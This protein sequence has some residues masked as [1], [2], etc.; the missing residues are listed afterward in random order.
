MYI[1][2]QKDKLIIS[3]LGILVMMTLSIIANNLFVEYSIVEMITW[4]REISVFLVIL[5]IAQLAIL[6]GMRPKG[7]YI[8]IVNLVLYYSF[9]FSHVFLNALE[10]DFGTN[11]RNSVFFRFDFMIV[12]K[13]TIL[14]I[15]A[16]IGLFL[17]YIFMYLFGNFEQ[18]DRNI[19]Y[20]GSCNKENNLLLPIVLMVIGWSFDIYY[21][22]TAFIAQRIGGYV[23]VA[24]DLSMVSYAIRIASFL[25]IPGVLLYILNDS[26]SMAKRRAVLVVFI[27]YKFVTMLSGLR[28]YALLSVIV[29]LYAFYKRNVTPHLR[30][31]DVVIIA[32]LVQVVGGILVGIRETRGVGIEISTIFQYVFDIRSNVIFNIMA[33]FGITQNV[34]CVIIKELNGYASGGTQ[35]LLSL[36]TV[37]PY[38]SSVFPKIDFSSGIL[39]Q[40]L[41]IHNYGGSYIADILFDF[42]YAGL[43][44]SSFL[45]GCIFI[46]FYEKYEQFIEKDK[47][48]WVAILSPIVIELLFSVRSSLAKMPR[49]IAWYLLLFF[50]VQMI[51]N[52]LVKG[53]NS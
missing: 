49:M 53:R 46:F 25:M 23:N 6:N 34:I 38:V 3:A 45:L 37:I 22:L 32:V 19:E 40:A 43:L 16:C 28:A 36:L 4:C 24:E 41:N 5:F 50:I 33:E 42:G 1:Q 9:N 35:L 11:Y 2:I 14:L 47:I 8:S 27:L 10:Y 18:N 21:S 30:I 31:R 20:T 51:T 13:S 15:N 26:R 39:E 44:L 29:V 48:L 17:G 7:H 52:I 12:Q